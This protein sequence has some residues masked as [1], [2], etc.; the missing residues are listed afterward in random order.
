MEKEN[1]P[2]TGLYETESIDQV[3]ARLESYRKS[4]PPEAISA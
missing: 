3:K 4:F 1:I 2:A